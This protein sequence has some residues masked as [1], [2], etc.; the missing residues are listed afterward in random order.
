A[1]SH[2]CREP[3]ARIPAYETFSGKTSERESRSGRFRTG[4]A[5]AFS[6]LKFSL[7]LV[8]YLSKKEN[9]AAFRSY[10]DWLSEIAR[11]GWN[12]LLTDNERKRDF[13]PVIVHP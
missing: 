13:L 8:G 6:W 4:K 5:Y 9:P 10:A 7:A 12:Y 11:Y 1:L 3:F 2:T